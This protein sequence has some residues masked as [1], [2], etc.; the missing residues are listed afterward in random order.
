MWLLRQCLIG[1]HTDS[2]INE[3]LKNCRITKDVTVEGYDVP[4]DSMALTILLA[5]MRE[6]GEEPEEFRPERFL[7]KVDME[8]KLVKKD[9]FV[10]YGMGRRTCMGE[11][12]A[13]DSIFIFFT[14]LVKY[15][16]LNT[17][18]SHE[19]PN[20]N[21]YTEGFIIIPKPYYVSI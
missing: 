14:N 20:P 8:T 1:Y 7:E 18:V 15:L 13:K 9:M 4:K 17:P 3:L 6:F 12:L 5:F 16:K 2:N 19:L 21:N 10:P 11:S